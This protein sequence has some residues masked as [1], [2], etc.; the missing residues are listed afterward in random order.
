[1][2]KI[3]HVKAHLPFKKCELVFMLRKKE[4]GTSAQP[5][6]LKLTEDYV[7]MDTSC[8][9]HLGEFASCQDP[10][11]LCVIAAKEDEK[12]I[13]GSVDINLN[14]PIYLG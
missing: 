13:V 9:I 11:E 14:E 5:S 3:E 1:M 2:I 7:D 4:P 12:V 8:S 6:P 10:V